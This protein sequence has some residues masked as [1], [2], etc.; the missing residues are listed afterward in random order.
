MAFA[1]L[2][3]LAFGSAAMG[4]SSAAA[5]VAMTDDRDPTFLARASVRSMR[6]MVVGATIV[7]DYKWTLRPSRELTADAY[8]AEKRTVHQRAADRLL[9]AIKK[10]GGV[11]VKLGQH[12]GSMEYLLPPEYVETMRELQ[13]RCPPSSVDAIDAMLRRDLG[14]QCGGI[15]GLFSEFDPVP[16]GVASLAQVHSA[17]E[18]TTGRR[19]AVKIQHPEIRKFSMLDIELTAGFV[20][21]VKWVFDDFEFDWLAHEM[22][23][24]LPL[25][26]DFMHEAANA[27]RVRANFAG[28]KRAIHVPEVYWADKRVMCMEFAPGRRID[29]LEYLREHD[30]NPAQVA[31][32]LTRIFTDMI[33]DHGFLH[34][35]P[36]PGNLFIHANHRSTSPTA[37]PL[38]P[39][40]SLA[41]RLWTRWRHALVRHVV[42]PIRSLVTGNTGGADFTIVVL[43][44][45]LYRDLTPE[46]S[47]GY[48]RLWRAL[49]R[50]DEPGIRTWSKR[51]AQV[52]MYH[53]FACMLTG[54][55]W[56]T[57]APP[58]PTTGGASATAS[59]GIRSAR[60]EDELSEVT[61]SAAQYA[62]EIAGVLAT[63]PRPLLLVFKTNDLLRSVARSL[64]LSEWASVSVMSAAVLRKCRME[65]IPEDETD[66]LV[67]GSGNGWVGA[68]R[69]QA[70]EWV[71]RL[72]VWLYETGWWNV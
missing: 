48:A 40:A 68:V 51:V 26:L 64:G 13:D 11:Y 4:L 19:V 37:G 69:A 72:A 20:R 28:S 9:A 70:E 67:G 27:D 15:E 71:V 31:C 16:L 8:A 10:S 63:V 61:N 3:R 58:P 56:E 66:D 59:G 34:A 29:D 54:R 41:W 53:L 2:R 7:A 25:E 35:D 30:I 45:G 33:F 5:S 62:V 21:M 36:H 22:R 32:E 52:D 46:F 42:T 50:G 23:D 14:D 65:P 57:I 47:A 43:D 55:S 60:P 24:N 12:I 6:T 38:D 17:V 44:H 18:R 49:I 1:P 39:T